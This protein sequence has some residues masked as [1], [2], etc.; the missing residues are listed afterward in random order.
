MEYPKKTLSPLSFA[1]SGFMKNLFY[2]NKILTAILRGIFGDPT[3]KN[4][5]ELVQLFLNSMFCGYIEA[6][7]AIFKPAEKMRFLLIFSKTSSDTSSTTLNKNLQKSFSSIKYKNTRIQH[8]SQFG[9]NW[10]QSILIRRY[11]YHKIRK[12]FQGASYFP[13]QLITL[14]AQFKN[15]CKARKYFSEETHYHL[16]ARR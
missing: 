13:Y 14:V 3:M 7:S 15:S 12:Y 8:D 11:V 9:H 5:P 4:P 16:K 10:H 2:K 1:A 6:T